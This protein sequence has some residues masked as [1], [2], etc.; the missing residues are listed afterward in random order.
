MSLSIHDQLFGL[1]HDYKMPEEARQLLKQQP[2]ILCGVSAAGKNTIAEE[3]LTKGSYELVVSHTTRQPRENHGMLEENGKD[4]FFVSE[5]TMLDLV[6]R[7]QFVEVKPVHGNVYG[8]SLMALAK[9]FTE[10]KTP[11]LIIDVQGAEELIKA[12]PTLQASFVLPPD[13]GVWQKR[14]H[15]RG[16]M[17]PTDLAHRLKN[18][19]YEI[20]TALNNPNFH[21]FVNVDKALTAQ[22][23]HTKEVGRKEDAI[24]VAQQL[25][26]DIKS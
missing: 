12:V 21:L 16:Q 2:L 24:A 23:M 14:L 20:E 17:H 25:L 19:E 3:L 6:N 18:A 9:P 4:Y 1:V 22:M 15:S 11:L 13:M 7:Q 5:Q 8:T 10:G 26:T